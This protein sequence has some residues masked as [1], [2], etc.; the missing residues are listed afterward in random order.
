MKSFRF[1]SIWLLSHNEKRARRIT[2]HPRRNL[3]L[4]T[5]HTGKSTLVKSLFMT[6][7]ATPAGELELWDPHTISA[8]DFNVDGKGYRVIHHNGTRALFDGE[9]KLLSAATNHAAWSAIFGDTVGFN[10]VVTDSRKMES[11]RADPA[12]FFLPFYVDQDGSWR[13][14]WDT[15]PGIKRFKK[16]VGGILEYFTGIKP[17]EYYAL[18]AER[19]RISKEAD[20]QVSELRLLERARERLNIALPQGGVKLNEIGFEQEINRLTAEANELNAKQEALRERAVREA[21]AIASVEHQIEVALASLRSYEG[22]RRYF[23]KAEHGTELVCPTCGA[24]H[25]NSFLHYLGYAEDARILEELT[26]SLQKDL[27]TA[28]Q[29]YAKTNLQL[30]GLHNNYSRINQILESKKGELKF[31]EV[32]EGYGAQ[33]AHQ[34]FDSERKEIADVL[35]GWNVDLEIINARLD[36]LTNKGRTKRILADFRE[37]YAAARKELNVPEPSGKRI[38]LLSRPKRSGSGG[39]RL[40]LA[41]YAA[42]WKVCMQN[43]SGTSI[44]IVIDS[45]NQQD[46]DDVNLPVVLEFIAESLPTSAQ[47]IVCVTKPSPAPLD[48]TII[49]DKKYSL[50]AGEDYN[51]VEAEIGQLYREMNIAALIAAGRIQ[52]SA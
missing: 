5:N 34:A 47:L 24:E 1:E 27:V 14:Q 4:G 36:A 22:D 31:R 51:E 6:L 49:F 2:F 50:L 45:P 7:G 33:V 32:V 18:N 13:E 17:A 43:N 15:F 35:A 25:E 30:K 26:I 46:Q 38:G 3:V 23:A 44:P 28:K 8:V 41:Y 10:L 11:V 37:A 20:V 16:P 12:C 19:N 42:L 48:K 40:L 39:P 29:E 52:V 9:K 21:E